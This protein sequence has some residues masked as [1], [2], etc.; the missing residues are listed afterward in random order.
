MK[1]AVKCF[2]YLFTLVFAFCTIN[3]NGQT[4]SEAYPVKMD[5]LPRATIE[6]DE[7]TYDFGTVEEGTKVTHV[8]TFTN[9]SG[10][11]LILSGVRG[12]CGCTVPQWPREPIMPDETASIT[13]EF[14]SR[15]KRGARRQK[16]TITANT[17][18]E[19]TFIYM[20]GQIEE[21]ED[22]EALEIDLATKEDEELSPDCFAVY[23]N[24]TAE[25][26][27]LEIEEKS[28]GQ[29]ATISIFSKSGQLMARREIQAVDDVVEFS[30]SHYPAGSYIANVQLGDQK[31][32]AHCFI[33]ID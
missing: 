2:P 27:K 3:L 17:E 29:P 33:V 15:N 19:Q 5:T 30:V 10:V 20:V 8:F 28:L 16:V 9:S 32:Q 6:F 26:I 13:V 4:L 22:S 14:N 25:F 11:P 12:S 21:R 23:P 18:P 7:L 31:P 1:T 24:P